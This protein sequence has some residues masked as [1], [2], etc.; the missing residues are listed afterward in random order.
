MRGLTAEEKAHFDKIGAEVETLEK[1]P[2]WRVRA[3]FLSAFD[4][5]GSLKHL[6]QLAIMGQAAQ[7]MIELHKVHCP[8][9]QDHHEWLIDK[10]ADSS[11]Y[12]FQCLSDYFEDDGRGNAEARAEAVFAYVAPHMIQAENVSI[13]D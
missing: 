12:P 2:A 13:D 5:N 3:D 8:L 7:E 9:G 10:G 11:L 4:Q 6:T 1:L